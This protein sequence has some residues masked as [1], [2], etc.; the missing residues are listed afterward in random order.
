MQESQKLRRS[1]ARLRQPF[2]AR[3]EVRHYIELLEDVFAAA[4]CVIRNR[5][6]DSLK[7]DKHLM[8]I[9]VLGRTMLPRMGPSGS[10]LLLI[11]IFMSYPAPHG[12]VFHALRSVTILLCMFA[13]AS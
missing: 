4:T 13:D 10:L 8:E 11:C 5:I 9:V 1:R 3:L 2:L 12:R 7:G 6:N